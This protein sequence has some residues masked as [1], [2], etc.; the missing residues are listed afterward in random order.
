MKKFVTW[1]LILSLCL[2]FVGCGGGNE[3]AESTTEKV[4]DDNFNAEGYPVVKEPIELSLVFNSHP[5]TY[6]LTEMESFQ[7]ISA[8]TGVNISVE[9][10]RS[11]WDEKKNLILA[12]GD[13]PDVFFGVGLS[14]IDILNNKDYFVDMAPLIEK[15]A[16]N[17]QAM[18]ENDPLT[19]K[20]CTDPDTGAIY[21]LPSVRPFRP[22]VADT[23][24][25]NKTWLDN[26]GLEIPQT[27]EEFEQ[28][29][30]AFR[31]LDPNGNGEKDEI[32][33]NFDTSGNNF[34]WRGL[35]GSFGVTNDRTGEQVQVRDG[36]VEFILTS[37]G[38]RDA[39]SYVSKLYSEGL[40]YPEIYTQSN[41]MAS[42]K[43]S[44]IAKLG[45]GV[46][47]QAENL[48]GQWTDQYVVLPPLEGPN[49]DRQVLNSGVTEKYKKNVIAMTSVNENVEATMRWI[50]E[51]YAEENSIQMF[52]GSIGPAIEKTDA[53]YKVLDPPADLNLNAG[54]WKW[55]AAPA[56]RA[57]LYCSEELENKTTVPEFHLVKLSYE[58]GMEDFIEPLENNF[59]MVTWSPDVAVELA[60]LKNDIY[61]YAQNMT[62]KWITE[63]GVEE[64]WDQYIQEIDK[65]GYERLMEIYQE[66]Y[67]KFMAN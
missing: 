12:S 9:T 16:P 4:V 53:G 43:A 23:W 13:L 37:E 38:Y 64:D 57:P 50:D 30:I 27:V 8:K 17:I 62:A 44:D 14:D 67:D 5:N 65:M 52:F 35:L 21:A 22:K 39:V 28:V 32:P 20:I 34:T 49:G 3:A 10:I 51:L 31:D 63:G 54:L 60:T 2:T 7:V 33:F 45:V 48:F 41:Y 29:L 1:L 61:T 26:L 56:D 19:K 66:A 11:G 18:F 40:V 55:T 15:Y 59:P 58:E 42:G 46:H 24:F 6:E 36:K 25:I 47:W